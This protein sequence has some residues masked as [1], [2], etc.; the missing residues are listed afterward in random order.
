MRVH[1]LNSNQSV[2]HSCHCAVDK[3]AIDNRINTWTA[4]NIKAMHVYRGGTDGLTLCG[5]SVKL[6][7]SLS[8]SLSLSRSFT[9]T[10]ILHMKTSVG[11]RERGRASSSYFPFSFPFNFLYFTNFF[12][13]FLFFIASYLSYPPFL[14]FSCI[15][16]QYRLNL[17]L[18]PPPFF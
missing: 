18:L 10:L 14:T 12:L 11:R 17:A 3:W 2:E 5:G 8:C 6:S 9:L 7:F 16:L 1:I 15:I 13:S 4:L